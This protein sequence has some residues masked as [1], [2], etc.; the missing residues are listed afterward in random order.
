[1]SEWISVKDR[2]PEPW[3]DVLV[4]CKSSVGITI[5]KDDPYMEIDRIVV[6]KDLRDEYPPSFSTDRFYGCV[7]HWMELPKPPEDKK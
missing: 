3:I 2:L 1:M 4:S 6:W 5:E 7:T